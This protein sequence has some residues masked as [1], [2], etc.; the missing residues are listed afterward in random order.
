[1]HIRQDFSIAGTA[2]GWDPEGW[3]EVTD[4][5]SNVMSW[6]RP[7]IPAPSDPAPYEG[8]PA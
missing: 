7:I 4:N 1:M 3:R 8:T 6:S 5:L 2:E